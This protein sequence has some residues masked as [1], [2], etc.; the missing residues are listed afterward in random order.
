MQDEQARVLARDGNIAIVQLEGR[1]FPGLHVQGDTFM[2]LRQQL[3]DAVVR[4]RQ[5]GCDG[6]VM[7]E[8]DG[9]V[10]EMTEMLARYE[11]TLLTRGIQR[12][13]HAP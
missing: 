11:A 1:A 4:L 8:L 3:A 2:E 12:P 10:Q 5:S 7:E 6:E 9:V 13:Y